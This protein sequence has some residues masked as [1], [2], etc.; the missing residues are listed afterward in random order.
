VI[1]NKCFAS[2][3]Y[4]GIHPDILQAIA[5]A[6]RQHV[7]AY[8]ND[9]YTKK[10][11]EKFHDHFGDDIDVFFVFN[12]T[13]ANVTALSS[14][15]RSYHAVICAETAHIQMDE[16]GAPEKFT[17]SKLLT[18][19]TQDGKLDTKLIA[20]H[21]QRVGDQHHVQPHVI[22]ISQSTE[23]GTVY[24]PSEIQALADFA[25]Q[26]N[27]YLHMD[28]ARI[29][30]A[31]VGLGCELKAIS[32]EVGVDVLSFGGTKNGMMIGEAVV[33][34]NRHLAHDFLYIRKQSMQLASK[35]RFIA[36]QFHALLSNDLW[37]RNAMH[38][39]NM[40]SLLS[41][42]LSSLPG[43]KITQAVQANAVFAIIPKQVIPYLQ[44]KFYFYVW[45]ETL[46][47]ARLMTSFDTTEADIH[48][49]SQYVKTMMK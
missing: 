6:N 38:A 20:R 48:E 25:H 26:H 32:K 28:G 19:P 29:S 11:I 45:N 31:A 7:A 33:F 13:G 9:D 46:S 42:Q 1:N 14:M 2:D 4:A 39:N 23:Y 22:S 30:N 41:Q 17:G 10:A 34:F 8:G 44:E 49:F 12:G 24:S 21:L 36:A 16:C 15:N 5:D 43:I 35:M 37:K 27:M 40:A 18:V 3:N 47:E